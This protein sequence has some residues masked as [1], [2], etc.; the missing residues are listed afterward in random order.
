MLKSV[1]RRLEIRSRHDPLI[2][3]NIGSW[4]EPDEQ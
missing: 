2:E 1:D 4:I 3:V